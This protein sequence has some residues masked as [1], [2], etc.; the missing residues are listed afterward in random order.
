MHAYIY[1]YTYMYNYTHTYTH[2]LSSTYIYT[3]IYIY[4]LQVTCK[5]LSGF[6]LDLHIEHERHIKL[7]FFRRQPRRNFFQR[8]LSPPLCLIR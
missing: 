2:K 5:S 3:L 7:K 4:R 6:A 1:V 8:I